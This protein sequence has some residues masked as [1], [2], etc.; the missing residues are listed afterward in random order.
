MRIGVWQF[1]VRRASE[2]AQETPHLHERVHKL[3]LALVHFSEAFA[4]LQG[5]H[6]K[7]RNQFHGAK[8]GRPAQSVQSEVGTSDIPYGD[9]AKLRRALGVVPGRPFT[10][11]E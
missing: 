1:S 7:L 3:E 9:K 2:A 6:M 5:A 11:Q 10:H 8:G 4:S